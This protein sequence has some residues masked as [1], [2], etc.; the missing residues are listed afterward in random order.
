MMKSRNGGRDLNLLFDTQA[1]VWTISKDKRLSPRI[2]DALGM[3]ENQI[4][5]SAIT[6]YEFADLERRG[7][8]PPAV[9][10][11]DVRNGLAA[12]LLDCPAAAWSVAKTL[13]ALHRDPIDRMLIA[14]AIHADLTLVTG[15]EVMR[16]Y[17]VK[18]L[19]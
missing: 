9:T 19:W 11:G 3:P 10:F 1:L 5:I 6:A 12:D 17:P 7:R 8:F 18:T 2:V 4:F 14:H 16:R 13:P 15:D